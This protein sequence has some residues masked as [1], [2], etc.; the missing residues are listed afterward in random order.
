[1]FKKYEIKVKSTH[2]EVDR[3]KSY[4]VEFY[5]RSKPTRNGF[6][7]EAI[8]IGPLPAL[9]GRRAPFDRSE[10]MARKSYLN[11]TWESWSGQS[12]LQMLWNK[13]LALDWVD[14]SCLP[15]KSPFGSVKEPRYESLWDPDELFAKG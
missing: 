11:R 5:V 14:V 4:K 7:H 6:C 8:V 1:M 3:R 2:P 10:R 15:K 12:V 9:E 13:I